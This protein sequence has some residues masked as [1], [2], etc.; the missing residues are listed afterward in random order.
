MADSDT[1]TADDAENVDAPVEDVV[2]ADSADDSDSPPWGD[3]FTPEGA[4]ET[5][6]KLRPFKEAAKKADRD[7]KAAQAK[8]KEFEDADK[9]D[10][11]KLQSAREE[12][13]AERDAAVAE[14]RNARALVALSQAGATHP[15]LLVGKIPADAFEDDAELAKAVAALKRKGAYPELFRATS[16]DAGGGETGNK[17]GAKADMDAIIRER[18]GR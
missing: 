15:D 18:L 16:G 5:I 2:G 10:L 14:A 1:A 3:N 13:K 11:E 7:L 6:Q 9:S 12:L 17:V 4:Y 8:I